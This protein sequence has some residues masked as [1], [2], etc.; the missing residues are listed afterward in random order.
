MV[1]KEIVLTSVYIPAYY[2]NAKSIHKF[3]VPKPSK[4][5]LT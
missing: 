1:E 2:T 3:K 5:T 4:Y